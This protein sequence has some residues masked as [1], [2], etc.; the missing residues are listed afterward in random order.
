MG[1]VMSQGLILADRAL[2]Y[3]F[4]VDVITHKERHRQHWYG[5]Q[6]A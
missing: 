6:F 5:D 2:A 3:G 1:F 4:V